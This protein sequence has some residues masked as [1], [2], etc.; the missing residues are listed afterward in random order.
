MQTWLKDNQLTLNINKTN[1]IIFKSF[2]KKL[3]AKLTFKINEKIIQNAKETKFLGIII[4]EHLTW[5]SHIDYIT[6]KLLK[7]SNILCKVRTT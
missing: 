3:N 7:V 1:Y 4:D 6:K 5:K 2:R